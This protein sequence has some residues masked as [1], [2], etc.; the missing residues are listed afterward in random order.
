[1]SS[2]ASLFGREQILLPVLFALELNRSIREIDI[3]RDPGEAQ[4]GCA[5]SIKLHFEGK[6][7][8]V[9]RWPVCQHRLA[10]RLGWCSPERYMNPGLPGF[11][12]PECRCSPD[13]L[14]VECL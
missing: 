13:S 2:C 12:L 4:T 11:V 9:R 8:T 3:G 14:F 1:M 7:R 6:D 10:N 5:G